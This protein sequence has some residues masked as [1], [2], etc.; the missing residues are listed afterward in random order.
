MMVAVFLT[1]DASKRPVSKP[2]VGR[3]IVDNPD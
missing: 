1:L 3:P 2:L